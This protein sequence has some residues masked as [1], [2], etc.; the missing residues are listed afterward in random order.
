MAA[1]LEVCQIQ[2]LFREKDG[3]KRKILLAKFLEFP[4]FDEDDDLRSGIL[5]DVYCQC[6]CFVVEQGL[7]WI[8]VAIFFKIVQNL[9]Q[10][11]ACGNYY[12]FI[13]QIKNILELTVCLFSQRK[14]FLMLSSTSNKNSKA[15]QV[16]AKLL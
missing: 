14:A 9:L 4:E 11:I 6:L 1:S 13:L 5:L 3:E 16:L 2:S 7:P 12:F 10:H 15:V 8:Q